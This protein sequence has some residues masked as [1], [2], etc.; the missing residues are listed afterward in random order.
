[1]VGRL[2]NN[3]FDENKDQV[4]QL[5]CQTIVFPYT[6]KVCVRFQNM[7]MRIH[8]LFLVLIF[9][10]QPQIFQKHPIATVCFEITIQRWI[11]TVFFDDP[12]EFDGCLKARFVA[13][14][15]VMFAKCIDEK[16][17]RINLLFGINRFSIKRN[18]PVGS[19]KFG[20]KK[21]AE[22]IPLCPVSHFEVKWIFFLKVSR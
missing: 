13:R 9:F 20:I 16:G 4:A 5:S 19:T 15:T 10:A 11:E 18:V 17:L 22:D 12:E 14:S 7:Q 2:I 1:M 6:V 3:L 21:M 8:G